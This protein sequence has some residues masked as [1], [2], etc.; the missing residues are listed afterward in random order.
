MQQHA[1]YPE[2]WFTSLET[3]TRHLGDVHQ[4]ATF[5]PEIETIVGPYLA[6]N[7]NYRSNELLKSIYK[8]SGTP[9]E[10]A[11][12]ILTVSNAAPNPNQ[13]LDDLNNEAWHHKRVP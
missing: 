8:S 7:G 3:V 10:G 4:T 2:S 9:A 11:D 13:I 5:R 12:L 1:M 6:R